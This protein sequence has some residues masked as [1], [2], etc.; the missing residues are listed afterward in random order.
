MPKT[1]QS[2][3]YSLRYQLI[4]AG[5]WLADISGTAECGHSLPYE[6]GSS[7]Q[8]ASDDYK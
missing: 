5:H 2:N 6:H 8:Y 1:C 7:L 3:Q 4:S